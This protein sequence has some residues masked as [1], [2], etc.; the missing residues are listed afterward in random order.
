MPL[1]TALPLEEVFRAEGAGTL[2]QLELKPLGSTRWGYFQVREAGKPPRIV[3][4]KG[5]STA[6]TLFIFLHEKAHYLVWKAGNKKAKPHG[7]EW[8]LAFQKALAPYLHPDWFSDQEMRAIARHMRNPRAN[9]GTDRA[10]LQA[11]GGLPSEPQSGQ[12]LL[13]SIP[14]GTAFQVKNLTLI[15]GHLRRTRYLCAVPGSSKKYLVHK[16]APVKAL[17]LD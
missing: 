1:S 11:L 7:P 10:L 2:F 5:L 15:K 13:E 6:A 4:Q 12:M 8:K 17:P 16:H 3:V 9:I 14:Y